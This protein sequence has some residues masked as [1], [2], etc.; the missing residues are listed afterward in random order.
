MTLPSFLVIG[1][2][3]AGTT[4]LYRDI[5]LNPRVFFPIDKEPEN[6]CHDEVLTDAGRAAYE[7]LFAKAEPGQ[8]CAEA[9][10]AYT[11]HPVFQGAAR[12]AAELLGP[13]LRVVYLVREP[14]ARL[15]SQHRHEVAL[16]KLQ[17]VSDVNRAIREI[18]RYVDYSR[19]AMQLQFWLDALGPERVRVIIFE[20][21]AADRVRTIEELSRFLG[22]DP[23][24]EGIDQERAYNRAEDKRVTRGPL[25]HLVN[26]GLYRS[27][28]RP[29][30]GPDTRQKLR[31]LLPKAKKPV[32]KLT[33]E[34]RAW[35]GEQLAEDTARFVRLL[36]EHDLALPRGAGP[37]RG[38]ES[39]SDPAR[40]A[41]EAEPGGDDGR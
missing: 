26:S 20:R 17:T 10:T 30:L 5:M 41:D 1:A 19:Y 3:K 14:I 4:T 8:V 32:A 40:T 28:I 33:A 34:S 7:R 36:G 2:M 35:A 12:R 37:F 21:Y 15:A 18:P 13:E 6:L 11:K 16:G 29:L 39:G 38:W 27:T 24:T 23:V 22:L 31:R 25:R 9:S